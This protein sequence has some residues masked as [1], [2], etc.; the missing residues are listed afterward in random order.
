MQGVD[1]ALL[2]LDATLEDL[3]VSSHRLVSML[4]N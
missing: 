1:L 4:L 2:E 3:D